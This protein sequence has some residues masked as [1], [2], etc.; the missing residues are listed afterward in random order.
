MINTEGTRK[1]RLAVVP[2]FY[3]LAY[4]IFG[5]FSLPLFFQR[6]KQAQNPRNLLAN[7][8]GFFSSSRSTISCAENARELV[9][10]HA[11]SV[12]EVMAVKSF[13]QE[14]SNRF[15]NCQIL[16]TTVT[17]TGQNV[18]KALGI[19][20]I[21][22]AYFPFDFSFSCR[23]FFSRWKPKCVFLV[24]TEIW[25]NFLIEAEKARVP[26]GVINA[27]LSEKSAGHYKKAPLLFKPLFERLSF[28]LAQ[29]QEDAERF[30]CLGVSPDRVEVLGNMKFDNV[31]TGFEEPLQDSE[32][33]QKWGFDFKD[34]IW[35][36]G[37]TH[38][39]EETKL[40]EIFF[41]LRREHP[42]LKMILAPRHIE[43]SLGLAQRIRRQGLSVLLS[44]KSA[45]NPKFDILL[46]DQLGILKDL[47]QLADVVFM[48]GSLV[49]RGGQNPIEPASF[50]KAI[51][52]GPFVFNFQN[53]YQTFDREGGACRV[54]DAKEL[55][56]VLRQ[57]LADESRRLELGSR[58]F[59]L[60]GR[61]QGATQR[62]LLW[63]GKFLVTSSQ[64]RMND[65]NVPTR[66][67]SP[68]GG[69]I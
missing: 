18:A 40:I 56:S 14:F 58:A 43:R 61:L 9:W 31:L 68:S 38:P 28:V 52:H 23:R 62:H 55:A 67:F 12:G 35:V 51:V 26:V 53:I 63:I 10:I 19:E 42:S 30:T 6:M 36:A 45:E 16:L 24:E 22:L 2:I 59:Q 5:L 17:P 1:L 69:R 34:Q 44:S 49:K 11:V 15:P 33:R 20:R 21:Q 13:L 37:S 47:Y 48:G 4:F 32:L 3:N 27:R 25:P 7:R 8:L 50:R 57:V 39:G 65:V 54:E 64:E 29:T 60:V 66:L 41:D 46:L